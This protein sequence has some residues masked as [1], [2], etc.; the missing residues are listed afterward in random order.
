MD[1]LHAENHL[2]VA[3]LMIIGVKEFEKP[4]KFII[5]IILLRLKDAIAAH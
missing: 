4:Y 1:T 2:R 3:L 5:L